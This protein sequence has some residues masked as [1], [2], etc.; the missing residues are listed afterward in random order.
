MEIKK[1]SY[2]LTPIILPD[3]IVC[4]FL[5]YSGFVNFI[6]EFNVRVI[7]ILNGF[8]CLSSWLW[9]LKFLRNDDYHLS[10]LLKKSYLLAGRL[11][12]SFI[13]L[14][15]SFGLLAYCCFAR[16]SYLFDSF[17]RTL[18]S[19]FIVCYYNMNY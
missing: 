12:L 16:Y 7:L 4:F 5:L 15:I 9:M 11:F 19:L 3:M 6:Q 1:N 2:I 17:H 13:P 14:F 8:A 18:T 10:F